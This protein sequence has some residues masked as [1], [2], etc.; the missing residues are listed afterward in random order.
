VGS[1][2]DQAGGVVQRP[3]QKPV[4]DINVVVKPNDFAKIAKAYEGEIGALTAFIRDKINDWLEMDHYPPDWCVEAIGEA[5]RQNHRSL[6]YVDAILKNW[7]ANGRG[8]RKAGKAKEQTNGHDP[9]RTA[10]PTPA[11][12]EVARQVLAQR[13]A[14]SGAVPPGHP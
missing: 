4:K 9:N 12:I 10:E 6:A 11:S 2:N 1:S 5:A 14:K 8:A 13:A 3:P 7:K